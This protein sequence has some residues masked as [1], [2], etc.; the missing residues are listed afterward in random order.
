MK[1]SLIVPLSLL[2]TCCNSKESAENNDHSPSQDSL[3]TEPGLPTHDQTPDSVE[4]DASHQQHANNKLD[5]LLNSE[6]DISDYYAGSYI[7]ADGN[8]I[9]NIK[10]DLDEGK[11]KI[12]SIIGDEQVQF[13]KKQFSHKELSDIMTYLNEFAE[14]P[15][16]SKYIENLSSWAL[17]ERENHVEVCMIEMNEKAKE[18]FKN[19]ILDSDAIVFKECGPVILE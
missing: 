13:R 4:A 15:E 10:G 5:S 3:T 1:L 17:M 11:A 7:D 16:N 12:I 14:K 2:L 6:E 9:I 18:D 19:H 8:L